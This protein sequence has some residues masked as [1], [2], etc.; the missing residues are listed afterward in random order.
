[1]EGDEK[2][3][4]VLVDEIR[5]KDK[6]INALYHRLCKTQSNAIEEQYMYEAEIDILRTKLGRSGRDVKRLEKMI[7]TMEKCQTCSTEDSIMEHIN[8]LFKEED[9]KEERIREL[10]RE[11]YK[12]KNNFVI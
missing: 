3:Y 12:P 8:D 4:S 5:Q 11:F 6:C 10:E 1:M 9:E 7:E 2:P